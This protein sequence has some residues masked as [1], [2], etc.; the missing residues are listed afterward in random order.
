MITDFFCYYCNVVFATAETD[1]H[2]GMMTISIKACHHP[3]CLFVLTNIVLCIV[4]TLMSLPTPSSRPLVQCE[5]L[6]SLRL[7]L[8]TC[9]FRLSKCFQ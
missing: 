7:A 3:L 8:V 9:L 2:L 5:L 4:T 1:I 6:C